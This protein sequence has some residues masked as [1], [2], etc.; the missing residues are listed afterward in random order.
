MMSSNDKQGT[1]WRD[2][3]ILIYFSPRQSRLEVDGRTQ[4][5]DWVVAEPRKI[6][7]KG[8]EVIWQALGPCEKLEVNLP[9]DVCDPPTQLSAC[10][11]SARV[12]EDAPIGLRY[13]EAYV[14]GALATGGSSPGLIVDP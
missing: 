14:N 1:P 8:Q 4:P 9:G 13:Y 7:T 5:G 10:K 12:R 6:V 3:K 11:V 2:E